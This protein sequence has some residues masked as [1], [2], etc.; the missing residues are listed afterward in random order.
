M[1]IPFEAAVEIIKV[2][3]DLCCSRN[4]A[5]SEKIVAQTKEK[6]PPFQAAA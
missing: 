3:C 6:K 2:K 4:L 5:S 1:G